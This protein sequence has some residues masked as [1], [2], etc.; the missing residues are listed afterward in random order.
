MEPSSSEATQRVSTQEFQR[1]R[2]E[3]AQW[4]S[5]L[6][7]HTISSLPAA[8]D[9]NDSSPDFLR[10]VPRN[11]RAKLAFSELVEKQKVGTL[12]DHH[13]QYLVTN[14]RGPLEKIRS[15][16]PES[17][18][19]GG[20][21]GPSGGEG[22]E[23]INLG[24]FR[25]NF[26]CLTVTTGA[27][28]AI[29][30]G[31][32]NKERSSNRNI[33]ILL[34]APDPKYKR[35]LLRTHAFLRLHTGSGVWMISAAVG[36]NV[37][38][39]KEI[40]G[41]PPTPNA[42]VFLDDKEIFAEM[43]RCL[44]EP[45]TSLSINGM[46]YSVQFTPETSVELER[47]CRFRNKALAMEG[48]T[49]P[50]TR[51][52]GI[53]LKS[54]IR[55]KEWAVFSEGLGSGTFATVWEGFDP[56]SGDLRAVKRFEV[57]KPTDVEGL[58]PELLVAN[59]F[60]NTTGLVRQYGWCMARGDERLETKKCPFEVYLVLE[61]GVSFFDY[62]WGEPGLG[63]SD[64]K[65][66]LCR[67]L[68]E[69]L[70]TIHRQGWMHRD[71]TP[72]NILLIEDNPNKSEPERAVLCDFGKVCLKGMDTN[73]AIAAWYYLPP[74]VVQFSSAAY[75]QSIDVWML[76]HALVHVWYPPALNNAPRG[77]TRQLT[78]KGIDVL[79]TELFKE[80][81]NFAR[82]LYGMLNPEPEHRPSAKQAIAD[83]AFRNLDVKPAKVTKPG[84]GS[85]SRLVVGEDD[86]VE[87]YQASHTRE[88][89]EL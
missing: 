6:Q 88:S 23:E 3:A 52:T 36:S 47:Y 32:G 74:E 55:A 82:L 67:D 78:R 72:N 75:N 61:K 83:P 60:G 76:A 54:D 79:Q 8:G 40:E 17:S 9:S 34:A 63:K 16:E 89:P 50:R 33:D 44:T 10:I 77:P 31:S 51:I 62:Q 85:S 22:S 18:D 7:G 43:F 86:D 14:G 80:K 26:D 64:R 42:T 35:H 28:W 24:W 81:S 65:L 84:S 70:A 58:K 15:L 19:E 56:A 12:H 69:G 38:P 46:E 21:H 66:R 20:D 37:T 73:T 2:V 48:I 13:T 53:P 49:L 87:Q 41:P 57:K 39:M 59:T 71:I 30:R 11:P 5:H 4:E 45:H 27:K 25:I 1:I 68:L 29:G